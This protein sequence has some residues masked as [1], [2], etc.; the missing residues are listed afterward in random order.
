MTTLP[1]DSIAAIAKLA[2]DAERVE[3]TD[4]D[5]VPHIIHK[6][7]TWPILNDLPKALTLRTL[8]GVVDYLTENRD[9]LDIEDLT[10]V[11]NGP[12]DMQLVGQARADGRR[13]V[14]II[15]QEPHVSETFSL[16]VNRF[17]SVEE[18]VVGCQQRFRPGFGD[19]AA[20]L[21]VVGNIT[22]NEVRQVEDDGISQA[23]TAKAG[24]TKVGIVAVPSPCFLV[25]RRSFP[26]IE[27]SNVPFILRIKKGAELP[28]VGLFE[29]DG[30]AWMVDATS[31]IAEFI[32]R[33]W[34]TKNKDEQGKAIEA[35]F[36]VLA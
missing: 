26:E 13:Q 12:G 35:P 1:A 19:F 33:D 36:G 30:A 24:I 25:P 34:R 22:Q 2:T 21:S 11:I 29:A 7:R 17:M 23:V 28:L 3:H 20:V 31:K 16:F 6:G 5:G 14:H 4:I 10:V 18:F 8:S 27:L 32:C 15:A 9:C